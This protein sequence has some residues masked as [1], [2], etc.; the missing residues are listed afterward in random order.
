VQIKW[1]IRQHELINPKYKELISKRE[2]FESEELAWIDA[3]TINGKCNILSYK[4]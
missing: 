3:T 1:Y 2:V 4:E